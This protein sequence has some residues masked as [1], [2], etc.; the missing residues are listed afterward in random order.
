MDGFRQKSCNANASVRDPFCHMFENHGAVMLVINPGTGAIVR[1]NRSAELF[2][3]YPSGTL[4]TMHV[5][6]INTLSRPDISAAMEVAI[7]ER[8]SRFE[9]PH[10]LAGGEMRSVEV[11]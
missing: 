1:A 5:G 11:H 2:Y 4:E 3:G 9:F 6:D 8:F 10:R 7:R